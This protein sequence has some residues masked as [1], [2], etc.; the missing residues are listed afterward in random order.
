MTD[1]VCIEDPNWVCDY[2]SSV[3][4]YMCVCES[5]TTCI[6]GFRLGLGDLGPGLGRIQIQI[7]YSTTRDFIN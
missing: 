5:V 1:T 4:I 7:F 3:S 2:F 6:F